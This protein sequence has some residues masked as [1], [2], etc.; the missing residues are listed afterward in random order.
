MIDTAVT[1]LIIILLHLTNRGVG[2]GLTNDSTSRHQKS[3]LKDRVMIVSGCERSNLTQQNSFYGLVFNF[4]D[5]VIYIIGQ[6]FTFFLL[7]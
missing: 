2:V 7:Q 5:T 3:T 1:D 4:L 6:A